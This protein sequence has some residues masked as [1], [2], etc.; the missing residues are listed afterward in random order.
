MIQKAIGGI[1]NAL[2]DLKAKALGVP[3]YELFGGPTRDDRRR[4]L[5]ALR[6]DP[7]PRLGGDRD[8]EARVLRRR[9]AL[10]REVV[11]RGFTAFK[12]NIVVPGDE[13][14]VLMPGFQGDGPRPQSVAGARRRRSC[15]VCSPPS[16]RAPEGRPSRSS[17]STSTSRA[18]G[19]LRDLARAR[20]I[21]ACMWLEVDPFDPVRSPLIRATAPM[22]ICSG[23]NLYTNRG[24][25]PFFE[26]ARWTSRRST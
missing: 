23:E 2:L 10:G 1:E 13:P 18:E 14:Q 25:R 22:P 26:P 24:F 7:R 21:T 3:V 6:H 5:V 19:V 15:S 8:A 20:A 12:T 16:P 11:E 4:V 9:D 17:T